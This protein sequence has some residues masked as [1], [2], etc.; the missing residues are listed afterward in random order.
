MQANDYLGA[1][2]KVKCLE[3]INVREKSRKMLHTKFKLEYCCGMKSF[4][5]QIML[6]HN[7]ADLAKALAENI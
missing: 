2:Y 5:H 3:V 6:H 1:T 4:S 7:F